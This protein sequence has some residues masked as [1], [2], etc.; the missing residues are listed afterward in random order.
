MQPTTAQFNALTALQSARAEVARL[1]A[2]CLPIRRQV[3]AE[4]VWLESDEWT[5]SPEVGRARITDPRNAWLMD[6]QDHSAYLAE[7]QQRQ[8]A[9]GAPLLPGGFCPLLVAEQDLRLAEYAL[10]DSFASE[11]GLT[12]TATRADLAVH[13][14]A[15]VLCEKA[16]TA[17][18]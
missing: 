10:I 13:T 7:V 17:A 4:R 2:I 1:Q 16:L 12:S 5:D 9:A 15:V 6:D 11:T 18:A 8:E 3:L 14:R